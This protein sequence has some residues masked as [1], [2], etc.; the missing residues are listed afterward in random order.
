MKKSFL[1]L[2]FIA[3]LI[4][5][6]PSFSANETLQTITLKD[7]TLLRGKL[8]SVKDGVY[9]IQTFNLGTL[10]V[11][12]DKIVSVSTQLVAEK[13]AAA[14]QSV[15]AAQATQQ[16]QMDKAQFA[17]Q[18][19]QM[20]QQFLSDPKIV[21][22]IQNLLNDEEVKALLTDPEVMKAVM[23]YDPNTIAGNEKIK[24]LMENTKIK[25]LMNLMQQNSATTPH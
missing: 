18:A 12:E 21:A 13:S 6:S 17:A 5:A 10:A 24:K 2:A 16:P 19:Q 8:I 25:N 9:T 22:E 11:S 4:F 20:Q 7:G 15:P 23:T 14:S 1:I 3:S